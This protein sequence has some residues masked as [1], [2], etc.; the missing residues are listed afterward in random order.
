MIGGNIDLSVII[1]SL[2]LNIFLKLSFRHRTDTEVYKSKYK[3]EIPHK[4]IILIFP[5]EA[6]PAG[7]KL[8]FKPKNEKPFFL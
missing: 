6:G 5:Y 1:L 8:D 4:N 3:D 7:M 2:F